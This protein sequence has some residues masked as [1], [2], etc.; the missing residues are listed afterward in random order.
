MYNLEAINNICHKI[1]KKITEA[2]LLNEEGRGEADR[3]YEK[4][5]GAIKDVL[6]NYTSD[7]ISNINELLDL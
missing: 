2:S 7:T 4:V 1:A 5:F 3:L 6:T